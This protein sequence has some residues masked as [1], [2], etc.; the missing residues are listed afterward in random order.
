MSKKDDIIADLK[1][2]IECYKQKIKEL[3]AEAIE[4]EDDVTTIQIERDAAEEAKLEII[5]IKDDI[6]QDIE[7]LEQRLTEL[8]EALGNLK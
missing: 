5:E 4:W 3:E 7:Y 6:I 2:D 1:L 8:K